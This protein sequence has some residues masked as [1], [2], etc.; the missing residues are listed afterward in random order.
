ME[1]GRHCRQILF[2][3]DGYQS[4]ATV[5]QRD[6]TGD[7]KFLTPLHQAKCIP[8]CRAAVDQFAALDVLRRIL[9]DLAADLFHQD[10]PDPQG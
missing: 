3:C 5:G 2:L 1:P 9:T 6:P 4:F 7:E 10:L 8:I